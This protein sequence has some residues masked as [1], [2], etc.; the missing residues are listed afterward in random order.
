MDKS[1]SKRIAWSMPTEYKQG[2]LSGGSFLFLLRILYA[3]IIKSLC[4]PEDS[5]GGLSCLILNN[6]KWPVTEPAPLLRE[7][8]R[9]RRRR[10]LKRLLP[11]L[12]ECEEVRLAKAP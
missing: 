10:N 2:W 3:L 12:L 11:T 4:E 7:V 5:L 6:L 1:R 8:L 9:M